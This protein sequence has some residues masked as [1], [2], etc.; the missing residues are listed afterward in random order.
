VYSRVGESPAT[1]ALVR[2]P[3]WSRSASRQG[4]AS[5]RAVVRGGKWRKAT[6]GDGRG[7]TRGAV[8]TS[9]NTREATI[10][11]VETLAGA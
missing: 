11:P 3:A 1:P 8:V 9:A 10:E 7:T 4:R 6:L 5:V 2:V